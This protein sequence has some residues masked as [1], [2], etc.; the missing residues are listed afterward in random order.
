MY[1]PVQQPH[2]GSAGKLNALLCSLVVGTSGVATPE[3]I[4]QKIGTSTFTWEVVT[5]R[6]QHRGAVDAQA[7][8]G[9]ENQPAK[10]LEHVRSVLKTT[11]T[12]LAG[13]FGVS[14]QALYNWKDGDSISA[15]HAMKLDDLALA[16]DVIARAGLNQIPQILRRKILSGKT[17]LEIAKEGGS[18]QE[19]ALSLTQMIQKESEQRQLLDKRLANRKRV[20]IDVADIGLPSLNEK[21]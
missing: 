12:D 8:S 6:P 21:V 16:A 10:Q 14:R 18:A 3:F 13:V 9:Q 7:N 5:D 17:L 2:I 11:F 1:A 19:A 20:Q 15:A 4:E